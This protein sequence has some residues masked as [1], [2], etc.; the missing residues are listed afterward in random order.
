[1]GCGSALPTPLAFYDP[2]TCSLRTSQRSF[3]DDPGSTSSSLT[4]PASGSMR[5]GSVRERPTSVLPTAGTDGSALL[6]TPRAAHGMRHPLR[7]PAVIGDPRSRLEDQIA[8]L[9]TPRATNGTKGGPNQRDS[10]G[11]LMLPSA[12]VRTSLGASSNRRF[13]SGNEPSDVPLPDQLS[14]SPPFVEWM[15]GLPA[16]HVTDI[17]IARNEKLKILGNGV[18]PQQAAYAVSALLPLATVVAA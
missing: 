14:L 7:N 1:M 3:L 10:S 13:D 8:I 16:G 5:T 11:D 9:P 2:A 18:V 4:L 12:V 6:G 17:N 15:M